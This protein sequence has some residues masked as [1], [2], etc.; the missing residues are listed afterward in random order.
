MALGLLL[1]RV[2]I[3]VVLEDGLVLGIHMWGRI[4]FLVLILVVV[5]DG[6][7]QL[8]TRQMTR[9]AT[10]LILVVVEDGLVLTVGNLEGERVVKS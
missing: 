3:L 5:E 7:V 9:E 1:A 10:V 8:T 2:L 4:D 6:L